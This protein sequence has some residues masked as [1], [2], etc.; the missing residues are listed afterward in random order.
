MWKGILIGNEEKYL[1]YTSH[2]SYFE[3]KTENKSRKRM[4][5]RFDFIHLNFVLFYFYITFITKY[6]VLCVSAIEDTKSTLRSFDNDEMDLKRTQKW[7]NA[8]PFSL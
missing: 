6:W 2:I 4:R 8:Y 5:D 1:N 3:R 7:I